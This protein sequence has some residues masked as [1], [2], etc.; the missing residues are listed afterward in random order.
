MT[1][2]SSILIVAGSPGSEE[3]SRGVGSYCGGPLRQDT[4]YLVQAV[5]CT[6][7]ACTYT[8]PSL[9]F[10]TLKQPGKDDDHHGDDNNEMLR[11]W[12]GEN[13][14]GAESA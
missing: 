9:P 14:G 1:G 6:S 2:G 13:G 10:R 8:S 5:L 11:G 4:V 3:C 12:G 7:A